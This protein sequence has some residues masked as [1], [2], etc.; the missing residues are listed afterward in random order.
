MMATETRTPDEIIAAM[1]QASATMAV[2]INSSND[3]E[4]CK[5]NFE[6]ALYKIVQ[7]YNAK[8]R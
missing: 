5:T 7:E 2:R 4:S 1:L 6:G 3:I 8:L